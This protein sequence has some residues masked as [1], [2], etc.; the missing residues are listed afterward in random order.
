MGHI[1]KEG[2]IAGP[3]ILEHLVDVVLYLDGDRYQDLRILRAIKNRFGPTNDLALFEMRDIGLL[4]ITDISR[5]LLEERNKNISGALV[6]PIMEGTR[7]ILVEIQSLIS[8]SITTFPKRIC[9]GLDINKLSL[10]LAILEKKLNLKFY[11]KD[12]FF[13]VVGGIRIN[14]PAIDLGIAFSLTSSYYDIVF[15][16]DMVV[17]GEVGLGGEVR[18]VSNIEK[19]IRESQKLGFRKVI[20]PKYKTLSN[21]DDINLYMIEN[22]YEGIKVI[23]GEKWQN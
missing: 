19:R 16:D 23:W 14:E 22:I 1:T 5:R 15:P 17:I 8:K 9:M 6:V 7:P 13:N 11:D 10:I 20:L 21:F 18:S 12:V 3:K 2:D 4:E